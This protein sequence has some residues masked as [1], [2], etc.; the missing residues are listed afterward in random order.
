M[1]YGAGMTRYIHAH[2]HAVLTGED[3]PI[4]ETFTAEID[5]DRPEIAG[6]K[7]VEW[8]R[9]LADQIDRAIDEETPE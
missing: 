7:L 4:S 6:H 8:L 3:T 5:E 2:V 1:R 9:A